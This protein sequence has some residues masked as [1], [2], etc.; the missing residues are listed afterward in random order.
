MLSR[1]YWIHWRFR[2][3]K[4]SRNSLTHK[5]ATLLGGI[6]VL[7]FIKALFKTYFKARGTKQFFLGFK[8]KYCHWMCA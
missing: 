2:T 5:N 1:F 7:E 4:K 6:F 3:V 8:V